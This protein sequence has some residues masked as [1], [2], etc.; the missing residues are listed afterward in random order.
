[1][2][3]LVRSRQNRML[4]GVCGGI[5]EYLR[6]DPTIVRLIWG[7]LALVYFT[8]VAFYLLAWIVIPDSQ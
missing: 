4:G 5:A 3:K 2:R 8:G 7:L 6:M 1:M